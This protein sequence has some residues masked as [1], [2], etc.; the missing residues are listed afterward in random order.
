VF[1]FS[2]HCKENYF[3]QKQES[4]ID[5]ELPSGCSD[6]EYLNTLDIWLPSICTKFSP[7]LIFYQ[8]GIDVLGSD[9]LGKL[10]L[11]RK[12][13]S[14]RNKRVYEIVKKIGAKLVITMGG[15]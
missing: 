10:K 15:G 5:V 1:T 7:N 9:R 14:E 6:E 2:I 11:T 12:G 4:N 8:A 13:C 3:S